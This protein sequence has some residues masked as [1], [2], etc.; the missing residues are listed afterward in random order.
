MQ[1]LN[2]IALFFLAFASASAIH[3]EDIQ[4]KDGTKISGKI[5][6]VDGD[7]FQVKTAYGNIQVPRQQIVS[8]SFPENV[9]AAAASHESELMPVEESLN[10]N[11]Y[12]NQTE[13]FRMTVPTG[14]TLAPE[15]RKQSKDIA[16]ALESPDQTLF[17]FMTPEQFAGTLSTYQVLVET[18]FQ[19]KFKDY[20]RI[21]QSDIELDGKKGLKLIW[22]AKN[23]QANDAPLK[24][25]VYIIPYDGR[26][27]RLTFLTLEPLFDDSQAVLEKIALSYQSLGAPKQ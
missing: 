4:L 16:A 26:M 24:G 2:Y 12:T 23:P 8:I 25:L 11:T 1:R 27:V 22:H 3:A 14:W 9:P 17:F 18:Q 10:G 15:I 20:A 19:T 7:T 21:S 13:N 6:S 5:I